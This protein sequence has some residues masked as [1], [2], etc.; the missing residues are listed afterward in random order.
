MFA[1]LTRALVVSSVKSGLIFYLN[2]VEG[3]FIA[4]KLPCHD[5]D[6]NCTKKRRYLQTDVKYRGRKMFC[7]RALK[8]IGFFFEL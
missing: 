5:S 7:M 8:R 4:V 2:N 1:P 3:I 6:K